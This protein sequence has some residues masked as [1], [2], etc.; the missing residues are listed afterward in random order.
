LGDQ[1]EAGA[2]YR[3]GIIHI[4]A[5]MKFTSI[6]KRIDRVSKRACSRKRTCFR[7]AAFC[8]SVRVNA[9]SDMVSQIFSQRIF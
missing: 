1:V 4:I 3:G 8:A 9:A 6:C 2:N 7:I 5:I